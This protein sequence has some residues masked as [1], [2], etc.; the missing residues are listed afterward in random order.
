MSRGNLKIRAGVAPERNYL[1]HGNI[2]DHIE[3][4]ARK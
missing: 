1:G 3:Q 4:F 2:I